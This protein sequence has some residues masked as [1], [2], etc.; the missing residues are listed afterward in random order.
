[1]PPNRAHKEQ[2]GPVIVYLYDDEELDPEEFGQYGS[3]EDRQ[4]YLTNEWCNRFNQPL[5]IGMIIKVVT[6][7][8]NKVTKIFKVKSYDHLRERFL[9]EWPD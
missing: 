9:L 6:L 5:V 8:V 1:M 7:P 2:T 4:L 3:A